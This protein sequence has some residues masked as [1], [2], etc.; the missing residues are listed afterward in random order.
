MIDSY[1]ECISSDDDPS[2]DRTITRIVIALWLPF[3]KRLHVS[4]RLI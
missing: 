3:L 1:S 4:G 2:D